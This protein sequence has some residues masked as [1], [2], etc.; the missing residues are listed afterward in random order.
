MAKK[1]TG[2]NQKLTTDL[3]WPIEDDLPSLYANHF[4]IT[5]TGHEVILTFGDFLPTGFHRRS[6]EEIKSFI[7]QAEVRPIAKIVMSQNGYKALIGL[8]E[9]GK[10]LNS[11]ED[12]KNPK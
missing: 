4:S 9:R 2:E 6:E 1:E 7:D 5:D 3:K 12:E 11:E 10:K 8:L